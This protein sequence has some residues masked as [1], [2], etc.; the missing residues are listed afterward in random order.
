MKEQEIH[1]FISTPTSY[2]ELT[3]KTQPPPAELNSICFL[4][5]MCFYV[6]ELK[7]ACT[8]QHYSF[9]SLLSRSPYYYFHKT[10]MIITKYLLIMNH[11]FKKFIVICDRGC[12]KKA[13]RPSGMLRHLLRLTARGTLLTDAASP[14]AV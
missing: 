4:G 1:T 2:T 6:I 5:T 3:Q 14:S 10:I 13:L 11:Y 8:Q 12:L 7:H 9:Y